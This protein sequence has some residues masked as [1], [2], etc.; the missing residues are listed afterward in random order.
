[1]RFEHACAVSTMGSS[2]HRH[3]L[4]LGS[5]EVVAAVFTLDQVVA[6]AG[7]EVLSA[8]YPMVPLIAIGMLLTAAGI[9][10]VLT[11][12]MPRRSH[13]LAVA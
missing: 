1:M 12:A 13:E 9:Y 5:G 2:C 7:R 8:T 6:G 3:I 10:G 11:F 4:G